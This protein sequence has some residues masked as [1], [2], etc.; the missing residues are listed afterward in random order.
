MSAAT[1]AV[2]AAKQESQKVLNIIKENARVIAVH[3]APSNSEGSEGYL[4]T[5]LA[6]EDSAG[7]THFAVEVTNGMST[8][9]YIVYPVER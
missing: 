6:A 1:L 7:Q 3:F 9:L 4:F 8:R 2:E 5:L